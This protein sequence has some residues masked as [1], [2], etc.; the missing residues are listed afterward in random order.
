[1]TIRELE[2]REIEKIYREEMTGDFPAEELKPIDLILR[3]KAEGRYCAFGNFEGEKLTAYAFLI[4]EKD[5]PVYLLDFFAV[6][7]GGRDQGIGSTFIRE[8][9]HKLNPEFWILE[10]EDIASAA[11]EEE[12]EIRTRRM[13]FYHKN[14]VKDTTMYTCQYGVNLKL[15]YLSEKEITGDI[16][17]GL[18]EKLDAI[19]QFTFGERYQDGTVTLMKPERLWW[20]EAVVYQIYPRSFKDSNGDGIGD[21]RGIIEKMDYL[22]ELGVDV[23]WLSPIYES[24]N[25]DN[26]YDISNYQAIMKEFGTMEDFDEMLASAHAHG[27]RLVMDLVVNHTSDEHPWFVESRKS[28]DN[29]YRDYYIWREGKDG[30]FPNNWGSCFTGSAWEFDERTQMYYLHLFS[31]KQPDLNW[32]NPVVRDEVFNMMTWWCEKGVDGFRMDVI[33]MISK[34]PAYPDGEIRDGLHGDMSPYVCNGPHVHEYLQEMNQRVLSKFDLITVGE[35]PGV[36]TEEAKKYANLDGSE[37]NMVFQFE[38]MGTTDG[39]YGKWTTKKPEMKK[40]RAVMN[41]WQNDLEG[42]AWNSLYWDN[43]DQ[44]RAVSRFGDDSPMYREVSAKMIA[45]CLHMLKG[46]PYI[47]QGEEIGMTN[48]YFKSI[49]DYKDIEAINAYKEYT[50]SGLMTEEEML[51]CLKMVSR[52]NARTP[53]QW[54]D[55]ANA[56]FTT[57][58]PWISVNK[59]YTQINAKAALE[60]KDSVFY[61]YQKLIRLRHENEI[62]VEGVFHGLLEDNDDIYAYERTL[63]DEKLVVACNFTNKEVPCDLFEGK[64]GE[65]LITNYK[66]HVAGVLQPYETRVILYK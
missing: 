50:E 41:K 31:K 43:H 30:K 37:L 51:N 49:D 20:K 8:L 53:M 11:N 17:P 14:G 7:R 22:Q 34:D 25:D 33:S 26:G 2:A 27:L 59:N 54:D 3:L 40:V 13:D 4:H 39:K 32:E 60:D 24:P 21:L 23:I 5:D 47:Y 63:G 48:A 16:E 64:E 19:Y 36:T 38:H 57:G 12:R 46:S 6:C 28:V 18:Y 45:T 58:T 9:L 29:P 52:D 1:M 55:S 62:I 66:N 61:Y 15:L 35:T 44:P 56:G 42:K 65:E 10:V